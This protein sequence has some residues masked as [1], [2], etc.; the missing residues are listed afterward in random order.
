MF[1]HSYED[2]DWVLRI[3]PG[4]FDDGEGGED[5]HGAEEV[6]QDLPPIY[7]NDP[8]YLDD[9]DRS[10][11]DGAEGGQELVDGWLHHGLVGQDDVDGAYEEW[12]GQGIMNGGLYE[13]WGGQILIDG[14]LYQGWNGQESLVDD[15]DFDEPPPMIFMVEMQDDDDDGRPRGYELSFFYEQ[16]I[17]INLIIFQLNASIPLVTDKMINK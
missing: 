14:D 2:D 11:P 9:G 1:Q 12:D 4:L 10:A 8:Q 3:D 6:H 5:V 16:V 13:G 15:D 17:K 7:Y